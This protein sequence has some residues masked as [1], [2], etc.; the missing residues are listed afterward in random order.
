MNVYI[1]SSS[2][3]ILLIRQLSVLRSTLLEVLIYFSYCVKL[4]ALLMVFAP[5][6]IL[7]VKLGTLCL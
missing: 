2:L 7:L 5:L 1:I 6:S 4:L 3:R